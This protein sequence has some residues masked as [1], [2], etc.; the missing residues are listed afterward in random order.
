MD[1]LYPDGVVSL[2][3]ADDTLVFLSHDFWS[4]C[5]LK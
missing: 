3:Y 2:Q 5:H 1:S 4:A